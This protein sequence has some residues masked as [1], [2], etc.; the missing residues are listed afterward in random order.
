MSR[1]SSPMATLST[2]T[3]R[4]K[5][6]KRSDSPLLPSVD[7]TPA[8]EALIK[9]SASMLGKI[10][11]LQYEA[12]KQA[13][14]LAK[15][16]EDK[17]QLQ[18]EVTDL[19]EKLG[20]ATADATSSSGAVVNYKSLCE[21]Q[22]EIIAKMQIDKQKLQDD[23]ERAALNM[24]NGDTA[25]ARVTVGNTVDEYKIVLEELCSV[26]RFT[27]A[28][29]MKALYQSGGKSATDAKAA[30][31]KLNENVK[32]HVFNTVARLAEENSVKNSFV[33]EKVNP[34]KKT[35][36]ELLE[37]CFTSLDAYLEMK[38]SS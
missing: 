17:R 20:L 33:T 32:K 9:E 15:A 35:I 37:C 5:S 36:S 12:D 16:E 24:R 7:L 34:F 8:V 26:C 31:Q 19:R 28:K 30:R 21:E 10:E 27:N 38:A 18:A 6:E 2:N 4:T 29:E 11:V 25:T 22:R 14:L 1:Q 3:I 23:M 13:V